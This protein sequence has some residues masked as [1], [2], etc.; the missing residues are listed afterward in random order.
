MHT[1]TVLYQKTLTQLVSSINWIKASGKYVVRNPSNQDI[2]LYLDEKQY[3]RM[4]DIALSND[5]EIETIA[6]PEDT[7]SSVNE[8]LSGVS[9]DF[10]P[11]PGRTPPINDWRSKMSRVLSLVKGWVVKESM[12]KFERNFEKFLPLYYRDI[13][14]WFG[15]P[16]RPSD[17]KELKKFNY[18]VVQYFKHRGINNTI[19][20][21][22]IYSIVVLQYIAGTPMTTT[23]QL[24]QRVRLVNG[25]PSAIPPYFR[26]FIRNRNLKRIRVFLTLLHSY[27][28]M[29]GI[30]GKPDFSSIQA[31][32]FVRP[33]VPAESLYLSD[34]ITPFLVEDW[35]EVKESV[36]NF[37]TF[38]NPKGYKASLLSFIDN[39]PFPLTAGPNHSTSFLG[40]V[41]DALALEFGKHANLKGYHEAILAYTYSMDPTPL[42]EK[43]TVYEFMRTKAH[44]FKRDIQ[45]GK[46][47]FPF[48]ACSSA[49]HRVK[50]G[51]SVPIPGVVLHH[52][53]WTDAQIKEHNMKVPLEWSYIE[54]VLI[55]TLRVGKLAQKFE[56]AGKIRVFAISDYWTQWIL[57]PL[58]TSLFEVLRDH[59]CDA[60]F[61]QEGRVEQF[62]KRNYSFI[63]SYDLKSATDLI[64]IQLYEYVIGHWTSSRVASEWVSLL[65]QR[66][67]QFKQKVDPMNTQFVDIR[68]SRGQP[69]GTLSSWAGLA[70]VHH[71]LVYLSALRA[72]KPNFQDY[73]VLGDDIVI[74]DEAV[75]KAYV[76][77]CSD[78]GIT[79]G[80]A[81]SFVSRTGMFQ[82]AS[83]NLIKSENISPISLKEALNVTGISYN[84]GPD[85]NLASIME[86][87]TRS[88][89]KG[90]FN[91]SKPLTMVR[92]CSSYSQWNRYSKLLT[93][94]IFPS[95]VVNLLVGLLS[96]DISLLENNFSL[97][98]LIASFR[99]DIRLFTGNLSYSSAER[100]RYQSLIES[101]ILK[102][103]EVSLSKLQDLEINP[104]PFSFPTMN[105]SY[106]RAVFTTK[107]KRADA[108]ISINK[109]F[110]RF[111]FI[112]ESEHRL[113]PIEYLAKFGE[114]E[115]KVSLDFQ[116]IIQLFKLKNELDNILTHVGLVTSVTSTLNTKP[117]YLV[118][119]YLSLR[120]QFDHRRNKI[121]Q[122]NM[123]GY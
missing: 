120:D 73:L 63:A 78:Y 64:P 14:T 62:S 18:K 104:V 90:Y 9:D 109:V 7:L 26:Q 121:S 67:Y 107:Y 83:Q 44:S 74:A 87:V 72:G 84:L 1:S 57:R 55:P 3:L 16:Y 92:A 61:E 103:I 70:M 5:K 37:W 58:H 69:M 114:V 113:T 66:D 43:A 54:S 82:F 77:V 112:I 42:P 15:F 11:S 56:A 89:R 22:K 108:L 95:E 47:F 102:E 25:L 96:K 117:P 68:Y 53:T 41:W 100:F 86:F 19:L 27:K 2:L 85:Y 45:D 4:L 71:F 21:L 76:L 99:G 75:A 123:V 81:K 38:I 33:L 17:S 93:K 35:K 94:G 101:S 48:L 49:F 118:K 111:K 50:E 23:Q 31:P 20:V 79:I 80:F 88:A 8:R 32:A 52:D 115:N 28:G 6:G 97:D 122:G 105:D 59:P 110:L 13:M 98:K 39:V 46:V 29:K 91:M 12:I 34:G 24:G 116:R 36:P 106:H 10:K 119:F 60:T 51:V 40:S 65:T 30:F